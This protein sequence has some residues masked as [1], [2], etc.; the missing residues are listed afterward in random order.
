M[1]RL[2]EQN[3]LGSFDPILLGT[4]CNIDAVTLH[5]E[6]QRFMTL[7]MS[8]FVAPPGDEHKKFVEAQKSTEDKVLALSLFTLFAHE[9]RHFWDAIT[10]CADLR[11]AHT[12]VELQCDFVTIFARLRSEPAL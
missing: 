7:G 5:P 10:T 8:A 6:Y 1:F 11:L 12:A 2:F 9:N 3:R 4:L